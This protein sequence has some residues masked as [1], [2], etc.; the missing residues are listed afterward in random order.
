M[1]ASV[2]F[3][4]GLAGMFAAHPNGRSPTSRS[5]DEGDGKMTDFFFSETVMS[6]R[7]E[8]LAI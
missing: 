8:I 5:F 6:A 3:L 7:F 1:S 4:A 2:G